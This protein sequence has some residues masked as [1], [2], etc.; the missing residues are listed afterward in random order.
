MFTRVLAAAALAA[1]CVPSAAVQAASADGASARADVGVTVANMAFAPASVRVAIGERVTWS[2]PELTAHTSTSDQ[3]FWNS[4]SRS[5]GATYSRAFRSA[6]MFRY[7]CSIHPHMRGKVRVPVRVTD[8]PGPGWTLRWSA[9]KAGSGT[10]FDIQTR[11]GT[12]PWR[13]FRSDTA[14]AQARFDPARSGTYRIRARTLEGD[15]R[16]GWSP[17]VTV[18]VS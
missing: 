3:G 6:G 13:D 7:H 11:R 15:A 17:V 4:G 10:S 14:K 12:G 18:K 8:A 9:T 1:L 5:G 16:S 2:F